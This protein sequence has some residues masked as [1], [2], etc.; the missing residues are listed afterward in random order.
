MDKRKQSYDRLFFLPA[1][2]DFVGK[3]SSRDTPEYLWEKN[4]RR[5]TTL[6]L[7]E[8]TIVNLKYIEEWTRLN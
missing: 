1:R 7:W 3:V 6:S 2:D 5:D 8:N 4:Q